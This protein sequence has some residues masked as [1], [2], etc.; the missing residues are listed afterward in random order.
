MSDGRSTPLN[1]VTNGT[2]AHVYDANTMASS[3]V[4]TATQTA[5]VDTLISPTSVSRLLCFSPLVYVHF[6]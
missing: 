2:N 1:G 4:G 3:D 5:G 6:S